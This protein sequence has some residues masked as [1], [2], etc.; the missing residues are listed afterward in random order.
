MAAP[1]LP[2]LPTID[3]SSLLVS[4]AVE[5]DVHAE[6]TITCAP[7]AEGQP[8]PV[9]PLVDPFA[10]DSI[11]HAD[12]MNGAEV[13]TPRNNIDT[14]AQAYA[15]MRRPASSSPALTVVLPDSRAMRPSSSEPPPPVVPHEKPA[16]TFAHG[17]SVT[18]PMLSTSSRSALL[19]SMGA[20]SAELTA[21]DPAAA[22]TLAMQIVESIR[23]Q[24][25]DRGGTARIQLDPSHLGAVTISLDVDASGQ[26]AARLEAANPAVREWLHSNQQWLKSALAD[27]QL[28]LDRLDV[29]E[30]P[31]SRDADRRERHQPS[32]R[33]RGSSRRSARP[34]TG[35]VFEVVA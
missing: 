5:P 3:L 16:P 22:P 13:E 28:T 32:P 14:G 18:S 17:V 26:V 8:D 7:E 24:W 6:G 9:Q 2:I 12:T 10:A 30:P 25:S 34:G 27:Q 33:E 21:A 1:H 19:G 35:D 29:A 20:G 4:L 23:L 15:A 31:E 11:E